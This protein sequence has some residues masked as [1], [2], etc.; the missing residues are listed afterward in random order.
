MLKTIF[1]SLTLKY[2]FSGFHHLAK[3]GQ[4]FQKDL[5]TWESGFEE[6]KIQTF[7]GGALSQTHFKN[8]SQFTIDPPLILGL[9]LRVISSIYYVAYMKSTVLL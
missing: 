8:Q 9:S 4:I 3:I 5:E 6:V 2:C 7:P 1:Y